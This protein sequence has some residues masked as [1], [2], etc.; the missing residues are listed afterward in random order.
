MKQ[1]QTAVDVYR[2]DI[3]PDLARRQAFVKDELAVFFNTY[4]EWPTARELLRSA[5]AR[6]PR[7][8]DD[9]NSIR[10]RLNELWE[11]GW[12]ARYDKRLCRVSGKRVFVWELKEKPLGLF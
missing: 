1:A 2:S 12:V 8:V 3:F 5:T 10:P 7:A 9:V 6:H 4:G 11:Q